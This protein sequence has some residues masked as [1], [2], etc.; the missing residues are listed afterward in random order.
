MW[1]IS[2]GL[3]LGLKEIKKCC[4]AKISIMGVLRV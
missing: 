1:V 2:G 3:S 4:Q